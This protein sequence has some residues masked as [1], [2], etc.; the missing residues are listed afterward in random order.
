MKTATVTAYLNTGFSGINV[1]DSPSVLE[2][3]NK[4][5][6]SVINCLPLSGEV[7][8]SIRV[9]AYDE[10]HETDYIKMT[11]SGDNTTY[12]AKVNGYTYLSSDTV[13]IYLTMDYWLT[14]GGIGNISS[15]SGNTKRV[16]VAKSDDQL[17]A[18]IEP[19][20]MINP[21]KPLKSVSKD[22][23]VDSTIKNAPASSDIVIVLSTLD[24]YGIGQ[25]Y[26]HNI[27]SDGKISEEN[28]II[29]KTTIK[30]YNPDTQE[31]EDVQYGVTIPKLYS[32]GEIDYTSKSSDWGIDSSEAGWADQHPYGV[33]EGWVPTPSD[34]DY[35]DGE[36]KDLTIADVGYFDA[37]DEYVRK[38]IAVLHNCGVEDALL[39]QYRIPKE[40]VD[41]T[42]RS[43]ISRCGR[44]NL[45]S[46]HN[47][48][49]L[50][51]S[52][53]LLNYEYGGY[54]V[55][56]KKVFT[57]SPN[58]YTVYAKANSDME[59]FNPENL[60]VG[61]SGNGPV[62]RMCID[63]RK[64]GGAMCSPLALNGDVKRW[65]MNFVKEMEYQNVPIKYEGASG[66]L[67]NEGST[68]MSMNTK[69]RSFEQQ[70]PL[71]GN[72]YGEAYEI[73]GSKV[74]SIGSVIGGAL[75][76]ID[77]NLGRGASD[78]MGGF[79][80]YGLSTIKQE[81]L[82]DLQSKRKTTFMSELNA[83]KMGMDLKNTYVAPQMKFQQSQTLRE[84]VG[85]GFVII[86][87]Q[88]SDEDLRRCDKLL[89]M[90]GYR[91]AKS[92][93]KTD[94]TNRPAFNYIEAGEVHITPSNPVP[95]WV[96]EGA[97][98]QLVGARIWHK[99]FDDSEYEDNE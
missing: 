81:D 64:E 87:Y 46:A 9:K 62:F 34:N 42:G 10:L 18:F 30:E 90:Y 48:A 28:A 32:I 2:Y 93:V 4:K 6:L 37:S 24:L 84:L 22:F 76:M 86:K 68:Y 52:T 98:A 31:D 67:L 27:G 94:L 85:N 20:E 8:T 53:S 92:L 66:K 72:S 55:R 71:D 89:T 75:N 39:A 3:S 63:L 82:A 69:A 21:A 56:N 59:T 5:T 58:A 78:I 12:F 40:Y 36:D 13:E 74:S 49:G 57:G 33:L 73:L 43:N 50:F 11:F 44:V 83:E 96:R 1:P 14:L 25:A 19:D 41:T 65:Y 88:M 54:T 99:P 91:H 16:H 79:L 47:N 15:I 26:D 29:V 80:D 45:H 95:K 51:D 7:N 17:F 38:G 97:E 60:G 77:G 35:E 23:D 70:Y 61:M